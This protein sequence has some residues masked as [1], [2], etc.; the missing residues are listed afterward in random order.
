MCLWDLDDSNNNKVLIN[1]ANDILCMG[2]VGGMIVTGGSDK[3]VRLWNF[4]N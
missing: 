1:H 2:V 3:I 4:E